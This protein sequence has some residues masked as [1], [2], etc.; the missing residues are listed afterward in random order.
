MFVYLHLHAL[1]CEFDI[2]YACLVALLNDLFHSVFAI[3]LWTN[4]LTVEFEVAYF[5]V[6]NTWD[7]FDLAFRYDAE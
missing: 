7:S 3:V 5:V 1:G 2:R 6:E 4:W